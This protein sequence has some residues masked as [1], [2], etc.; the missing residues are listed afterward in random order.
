M[1]INWPTAVTDDGKPPTALNVAAKKALWL[2]VAC[3]KL[4]LLQNGVYK[5]VRG[6][7]LVTPDPVTGNPISNAEHAVLTEEFGS[8]FW[9]L[10]YPTDTP[11]EQ[12]ADDWI[13]EHW[14][15]RQDEAQAMRASHRMAIPE[16]W[17]SLVDLRDMVV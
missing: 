7:D 11:T 14:R 5:W 12:Q 9:P 1:P 10:T 2:F 4:R 15:P 3:E 13:E 6:A 17:F 8:G 16:A